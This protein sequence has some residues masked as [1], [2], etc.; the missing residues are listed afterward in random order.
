MISRSGLHVGNIQLE[1][2]AWGLH[3]VNRIGRY[4]AAALMDVRRPST[5]IRH[6]SVTQTLTPSCHSVFTS[7]LTV[8]FPHRWIQA[9]SVSSLIFSYIF[10]CDWAF[11][12]CPKLQKR[13][14]RLPTKV[15]APWRASFLTKVQCFQ[16]WTGFI[17]QKIQK[18]FSWW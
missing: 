10:L 2:G 13:Q 11:P 9:F 1:A 12:T 7:W 16:E 5:N 15:G 8:A 17:W 6:M 3:S 14:E 18:R 4:Q